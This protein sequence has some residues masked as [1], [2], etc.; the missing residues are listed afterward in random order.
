MKRADE[1]VRAYEVDGTPAIIVNGKYRLS[2]SS[3]GGYPQAVELTQWLVSKEAA[4]K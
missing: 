2:P 4:G 1:L 3:A